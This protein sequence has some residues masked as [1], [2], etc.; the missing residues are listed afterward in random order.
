MKTS[1]RAVILMVLMALGLAAFGWWQ[2]GD[3]PLVEE[4][5]HES[6]EHDG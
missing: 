3:V 2:L 6:V 1:I 4:E 5:G